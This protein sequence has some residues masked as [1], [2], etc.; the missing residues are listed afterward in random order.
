MAAFKYLPLSF[1][2]L[3]VCEYEDIVSY[4]PEFAQLKQIQTK[5]DKNQLLQLLIVLSHRCDKIFIKL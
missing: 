3:K 2:D 1:V 4:L 5:I